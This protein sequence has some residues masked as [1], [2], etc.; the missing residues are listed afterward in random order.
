MPTIELDAEIIDLLRPIFGHVDDFAARAQRGEPAD[1]AGAERELTTLVASFELGCMGR[2]LKALDPVA[3]RVEVGGRTYRRMNNPNT[4]ASYFTMRGAVSVARGLYR[5]EEVRNGPTIVPM[6]LR[7]GIVE[8]LLTPAAAQGIAAVGQAV[9]SREAEALCSRLGVLPYSRSE[10]F[11]SVVDVGTRWGEIRELYEDSL[12][13]GMALPD[14]AA[15]V[16]VAVDRVSLPMAE[17]RELTPEDEKRGVKKPIKVAFRM[18]YSAVLTLHDRSGVP[19]GCIR[20]AHVPTDGAAHVTEALREDLLILLRRRPELDIVSLADGAPEMQSILDRVT[21]GLEVKVAMIDFWHLLEK[22][23]AAATAVGK[24]APSAIARFRGALLADDDAIK[25]V[26]AELQ[27]WALPYAPREGPPD[28]ERVR[29]PPELHAALTY[30]ANNA[31]KMR[32]ATAHRAG[33]PIGSGTVE[34]TGKTIVETRM[35]RAGARWVERGAQPVLA[36]RAL[37]TSSGTRWGDAIAHVIKSYTAHIKPLP[38]KTRG[39]AGS[40]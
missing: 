5:D 2:M 13:E 34:A 30:L 31:P 23:G 25:A 27:T 14:A 1:F 15:A 10:H 7:A 39:V 33:L 28:D 22:L 16:S 37:A 3:P 19:L 29:I 32:Y 26:E 20:Y 4:E 8:G 18:A 24:P 12:V 35:R 36:L 11:R 9:P 40:P 17:K 38:A 21:S 6:E